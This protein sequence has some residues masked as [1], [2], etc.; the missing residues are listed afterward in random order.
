MSHVINQ[1]FNP[2]V[3]ILFV[4]TI[5]PSWY[6]IAVKLFQSLGRDSVCSYQ[7][8]HHEQD[9]S[10][11]VSIPRSGFCLFILIVVGDEPGRGFVSIPRSGF[12][13]FILACRRRRYNP[14]CVSIPRSGFCL[15]ILGVSEH[16]A[17]F[18][19]VSIPRSGFCLFIPCE[20]ALPVHFDLSFNP[21]VGILFVH[22]STHL[23]FPS[24]AGKFQSLGRDSVCSYPICLQD[25]AE[26][27]ASF[28][29]SVGI[30]FVHTW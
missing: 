14:R 13:L 27:A 4:H 3:G 16:T 26:E 20:G 29:P 17:G 24:S 12:C 10:N 25:G 28:N 7:A 19:L 2:S 6:Q 22:T 21:S 15:F 30:L 18:S 1:S 9:R 11:T 5:V 8:T 23:G